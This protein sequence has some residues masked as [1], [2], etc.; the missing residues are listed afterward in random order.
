MNNSETDCLKLPV[1]HALYPTVSVEDT[2]LQGEIANT[3]VRWDRRERDFDQ[4]TGE[5]VTE[6]EG[7]KSMEEKI[8]E[9]G[10]RELYD[11][12]NHTMDHRKLR[13]S[14]IKAN[15]RLILPGP[16]PVT[17]E[18]ELTTRATLLEKETKEYLTRMRT[19]SSLT[20]SENEGAKSLEK[21]VKEN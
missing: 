9:N 6:P 15:P 7:P 17:E 21:R 20:R 3:K 1:K 18:A 8:N 19:P 12:I 4:E 13:A 11:P 14:D 16:R 10:H 5:E 2:R